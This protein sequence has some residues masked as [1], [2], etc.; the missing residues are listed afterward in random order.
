M[1]CSMLF[2]KTSCPSEPG[3]PTIHGA[4]HSQRQILKTSPAREVGA[5]IK[6]LAQTPPS[7]APAKWRPFFSLWTVSYFELIDTL[8][9][10]R[11]F[12]CC[13]NKEAKTRN[14]CRSDMHQQVVAHQSTTTGGWGGSGA[15]VHLRSVLSV[16]IAWN[17][18]CRAGRDHT[19]SFTTARQIPPRASTW[20]RRGTK[21]LPL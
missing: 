13:S 16:K 21:K 6:L 19:L 8:V 4:C 5:I 14:G 3:E 7:H 11:S 10:L 17:L 9:C 20:Q 18:S 12:S 1:V 2:I 15:T